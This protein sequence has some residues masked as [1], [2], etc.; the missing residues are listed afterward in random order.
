[1]RVV[2]AKCMNHIY[3]CQ[4]TATNDL[5]GTYFRFS[6]FLTDNENPIITGMPTSV[7][8]N[9]DHG[10]PTATVSWI[11]PAASDNSGLQT[12]TST[13]SRYSKFDIGVTSVEY[14]SIDRSGNKVVKSFAVT[15]EGKDTLNGI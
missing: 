10:L 12:L 13:H 14:T 15:V 11:E 2:Y 5:I 3:A 6:N 8:Q 7:T 9:T 1:M 4:N